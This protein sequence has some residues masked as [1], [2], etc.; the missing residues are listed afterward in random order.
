MKN[1]FLVLSISI[2]SLNAL[3]QD[4]AIPIEAESGTLGADYNTITED[5]VTYITPATDFNDTS[6]PGIADKVATYEVT[7]EAAGAYDLNVRV[8][9]GPE[10]ATDDSFYFANSFGAKTV[11]LADDW[12]IVN[13]IGGVGV[14]GETEYV[15]SDGVAGTEIWKWINV[16][17]YE[18][19]ETPLVFTVEEE[20]LTQSIQLGAR[21]NGLDID[22]IAFTNAD[23][24]YTGGDLISGGE[25]V[26]ELP[27]PGKTDPIAID[28]SKFLG[29]A[30]SNSQS[31]R[32]D[33]HW[34]QVTPEN[35]GKWGSVVVFGY[36]YYWC[37]VD[38]GFF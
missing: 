20:A 11:D 21:E 5:D 27:D 12:V 30:H 15:S 13:N 18:R 9:V 31:A 38:G 35:G 19:T 28:Q 1:Y 24:Y 34:N 22:M 23:R 2:L 10:N 14:A 17:E 36:Y 7:F 32:F 3:A 25:G 29:S 33:W 8:R 6:F 4:A 16:S 37:S 26:D